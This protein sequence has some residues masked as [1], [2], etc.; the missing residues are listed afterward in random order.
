MNPIL[1]GA[2]SGF[3]A[4]VPMT[5]A[6]VAMHRR[7]PHRERYPLPPREITERATA[8]APTEVREQLDEPELTALALAAHFGY[9]AGTGAIYG[10]L[11][12]R[13]PGLG[14]LKGVA[15]GLAVWAGS[16]LGY[17]PATGLFRPVDTEPP[18]RNALM[19]AAHVVWGASLGLLAERALDRDA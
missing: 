7:L 14:V 16:Y 4:T 1:A 6:M 11:A 15:F 18:R 9:G 5:A 12:P 17:L 19:I 10:A 8:A 2:V 3:A 13:V